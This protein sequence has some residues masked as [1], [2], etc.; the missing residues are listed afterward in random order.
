MS[1]KTLSASSIAGDA[2]GGGHDSPSPPRRVWPAAARTW[3]AGGSSSSRLLVPAGTTLGLLALW[4]LCSRSGM[5]PAQLPP[6]SDVISWLFGQLDQSAFWTAVGQTVW[7]WFAGLIMGALLGGVL[8][9]AIGA[10]APVQ[11]LLDVV[12]EFLRPIPSIVYLPIVILVIG[13]QPRTAIILAAV[14]AF[15]PMLYQTVYGVHAIDPQAIETGKVFGLTSRQRLFRIMLPSL[16]PY[17]ATGFRIASSLALVVAV[18]IEL[19]G[20]IPGLGAELNTYSQNSVYPAMYGVLLTSGVL[21]LLLN[22]LLERS[23][24]RLLRWHVSHR[25]VN[26]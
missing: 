6:F 25:A 26:S 1:S 17:L 14:G 7:Q 23:E 8:G 16:L 21:G 3:A 15:W 19:I 5:L 11:R 10:F 9:I 2:Q 12:L 20:G 24:R 4:E 18:S 22:M 13:T